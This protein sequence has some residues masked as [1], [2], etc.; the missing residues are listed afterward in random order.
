MLRLCHD[1]IKNYLNML[2]NKNKLLG[3]DS[4][5]TEYLD[6]V[7]YRLHITNRF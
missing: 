7:A 2:L 5:T 1:F 6:T 3:N 4:N